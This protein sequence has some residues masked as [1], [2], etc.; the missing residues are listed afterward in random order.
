M[1]V[2]THGKYIIDAA[3]QRPGRLATAIAQL[4]MGKNKPDY[5]PRVDR[6]GRVV[7]ENVGQMVF[8]GKKADKKIYRHH[9]MYPG[10]LKEVPAK[11]MLREEP[12]E[13]LRHAVAKMLPK[14]KFR[15]DRLKRLAIK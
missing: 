2:S 8:S 7:V 9:T 10:G 12:G 1:A 11:K 6:G 3:G 4:L 15:V 5:E 14:N 13:V